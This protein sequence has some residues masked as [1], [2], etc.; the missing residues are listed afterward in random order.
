MLFLFSQY[1]PLSHKQ[2]LKYIDDVWWKNL[3]RGLM[4][5][6]WATILLLIL[7]AVLIAIVQ[8][9]H[10][11]IEKK[12]LL[13]IPL[14]PINETRTLYGLSPISMGGTNG[15]NN[16]PFV[17]LDIAESTSLPPFDP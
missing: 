2:L 9:Q 3:R 12:S 17:Y 11:C 14:Q 13:P 5:A 8:Y 16:A 15:S 10:V 1:E 7:S 6:F 4:I